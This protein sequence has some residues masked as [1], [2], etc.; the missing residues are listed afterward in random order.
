MVWGGSICDNLPFNLGC[1]YSVTIFCDCSKNS[2][3]ILRGGRITGI[4]YRSH[5]KMSAELSGNLDHNG[6]IPKTALSRPDQRPGTFR[7][8]LLGH[9]R[10]ANPAR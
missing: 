5:L 7:S 9:A 3:K 10:I 2:L 6:S 1:K 4:D 8:M